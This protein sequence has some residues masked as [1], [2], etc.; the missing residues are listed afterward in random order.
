MKPVNLPGNSLKKKSLSQDRPPPKKNPQTSTPS[1][2]HKTK[3]QKKL[4]Q[5]PY[6]HFILY[7]LISVNSVKKKSRRHKTQLKISIWSSLCNLKFFIQI[8]FIYIFS[9]CVMN[10]AASVLG[11]EEKEMCS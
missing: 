9:L 6:N 2:D 4:N 5:N 10:K 7:Y 1:Q 11:Y 3:K 8:V